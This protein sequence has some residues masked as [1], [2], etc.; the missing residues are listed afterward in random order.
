MKYARESINLEIFQNKLKAALENA[1][2][3][4][5]FYQLIYCSTV[6]IL[7]FLNVLLS[8]NLEG[9]LK[10]VNRKCQATV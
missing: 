10:I 5:F 7:L 2:V 3:L 1:S 6:N 4:I 8:Y 9:L